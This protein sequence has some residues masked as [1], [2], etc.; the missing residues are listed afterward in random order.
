MVTLPADDITPSPSTGDRYSRDFVAEAWADAAELAA[1]FEHLPTDQLH[2]VF[3]RAVA[4]RDLKRLALSGLPLLHQGQ[5]R[6]PSIFL[7]ARALCAQG[8]HAE[9]ADALERPIMLRR[10]K[11]RHVELLASALA[12]DGRLEQALEVVDQAIAAHPE[13]LLEPL[14][15]TLSRTGE[16]AAQEAALANWTEIVEL[17]RGYLELG[18]VVRAAELLRRTMSNAATTLGLSF[19]DQLQLAELALEAGA[20]DDALAYVETIPESQRTDE[21]GRAI[22]VAA[23]AL[24]SRPGG[25]ATP[26]AARDESPSLRFWRAVENESRGELDDAIRRLCALAEEFKLNEGIRSTLARCVG[27]LVLS[28]V[29]PSF[30]PGR[31]GRIVNVMPFFN[32]LGLLRLHLE[33]MSPWVDRFVIVEGTK[34]FTGKDKPLV[35]EANRSLFRDF[36]AKIAY[37]PVHA[38]PAHLTSPWAREFYQRDMAIAGASGFCGEEDYIVETDLDEIINGQPLQGFEADFAALELTLSRFF[39]NYRPAEESPERAR[40]KSTIFKAKHRR[41]HGLSYC[42]FVLAGVHREAHLVPNSGWHFTSVFDAAGI[43]LKVNSYAHQEHGKPE[44]RTPE[45]FKT[46]LDRL[47]AGQLEQGWERA[48]LDETF[49]AYVRENPQAFAD[50]IL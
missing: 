6:R 42:R 22:A 19:A 48:E 14:R 45:H 38:Y 4:C 20:A 12:A 8:R 26:G 3:A 35:F 31:T 7:L 37:V 39:L 33:E 40:V 9:A 18:L 24:A 11:F 47:R 43:S 32:E 23:A 29:R 17:V 25:A 21:R 44:F 30:Q 50:M 10:A 1:Q 41:R 34:T 46:I 27:K 5:L 28:E 36:E 49:P 16:L 13:F 2:K 15:K